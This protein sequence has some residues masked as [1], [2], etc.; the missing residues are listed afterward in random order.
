MK[1]TQLVYF[2]PIVMQC[3]SLHNKYGFNS[4]TQHVP[5]YKNKSQILELHDPHLKQTFVKHYKVFFLRIKACNCK[6]NSVCLII[7]CP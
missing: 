5:S 6:Y 7:D 4:S 3:L 2:S 1:T